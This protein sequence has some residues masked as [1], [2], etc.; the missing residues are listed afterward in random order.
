M[1]AGI[2][3]TQQLTDLRVQIEAGWEKAYEE[4]DTW[5]EKVAM[6]TDSTARAN[7]YHWIANQ[8]EMREWIGPRVEQALAEHSYEIP[9][10][11][12]ELTIALDR[13]DVADD[14]LGTF[15]GIEVPQFAE[16]VRKHPD[17]QIRKLMQSNPIGFDGKTL[18]ANDHPT[19]APAVLDDGTTPA[20]TYDNDDSAAT[21]DADLIDTVLAAGATIPGENGLAMGLLYDTVIVPPQ[22][23]RQA[24]EA[25]D[26]AQVVRVTKN[27]AGTEN[28]SSTTI[29]NV[30]AGAVDV[31]VIPE[32]ANQPNVI[33]FARLKGRIKPF[34][35]Q[36]RADPVFVS[37][38]DPKDVEMFRQKK[39][40]F[41]VDYRAGF[42]V[43]LPFL[44]R[45]VTI[46]G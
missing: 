26:S 2:V 5:H 6:R 10:K 40:I 44:I 25:A 11:D 19:F 34:V 20:Q 43:S 15:M 16:A 8:L 30:M 45:R 18:F 9:N 17:L 1:G 12:F 3:T 7:V 39:M 28:V 35:Y 33:Y 14:T 21:F 13:N 46:T 24:L 23:R 31:L 32:L 36:V 38:T 22:R 4:T 29:P 27:V 42:G 37:F 41:G